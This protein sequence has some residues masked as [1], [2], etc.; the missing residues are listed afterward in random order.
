MRVVVRIDAARVAFAADV[1]DPAHHVQ[2]LIEAVIAID[3]EQR[4]QLLARVVVPGTDLVVLDDDELAVGRNLETGRL[5]DRLR[6][7]RDGLRQPVTVLVPH[8][9][10]DCIRLSFAREVAAF[11]DERCD[12]RVV[13]A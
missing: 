5:R 6:R 9:F 11:L 13:D 10:F 1:V 4:G 7:A 12:Q 2:R 8:H 3:G